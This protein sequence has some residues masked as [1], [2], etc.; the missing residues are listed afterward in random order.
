NFTYG[1]RI[2]VRL[3]SAKAFPVFNVLVVDRSAF[4]RIF[5]SC[6]DHP[7]L[8]SFPTRRS[9][10]LR[11]QP[12]QLRSQSGSE[13]LQQRGVVRDAAGPRSEEHTSELQSQSKLVCR[14]LLE[15]KKRSYKSDGVRSCLPAGC[16]NG[17]D[18]ATLVTICPACRTSPSRCY[19]S[20]GTP[21]GNSAT[22]SSGS[23]F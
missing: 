1:D 8:H 10:D 6:G 18:A 5:Y 7:A 19:I 15:K 14:L 11:Q 17:E 9:S 2:T 16:A 12:R 20:R 3:W 4:D 23:D 13:L 21:T 22:T